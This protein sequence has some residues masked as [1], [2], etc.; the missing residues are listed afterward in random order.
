M[1]LKDDLAA[2]EARQPRQ[3]VC[4]KEAF[5]ERPTGITICPWGGRTTVFPWI[6]FDHAL[7][8]GD[9]ESPKLVM[10]FSGYEV[11]AE[12]INLLGLVERIREQRITCLQ[13]LPPGH[14]LD[15]K[16]EGA[17]ITHLNVV[18]LGM[19]GD[20]SGLSQPIGKVPA[21]SE[22]SSDREIRN[23]TARLTA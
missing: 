13:A 12:G 7:Y 18:P 19:P 9:A 11:T 20:C 22:L 1:S 10:V 14:P 2:L 23:G 3:F 4:V 8:E 17:L 16:R 21:S 5:N 15:E 6:R